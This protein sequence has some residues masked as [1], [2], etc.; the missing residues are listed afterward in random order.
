MNKILKNTAKIVFLTF[1]YAFNA[2]ASQP[3]VVGKLMGQ[4]GNQFF[5]IAATSC[6]AWDNGAEPYFPSLLTEQDFNIPL[7]HRMIFYNLNA[8]EPEQEIDYTYFESKFT[9]SPIPYQPNM[10]IFGWFQSDKYFR[11]RKQEIIE[12]FAPD[13]EIKCYLYEKYCSIIL[14]PKTVS[15]HYRSY[16]KE[17][18]QHIVYSKCDR[19][20]YQRAISQFSEDS[21]FVVFSNDIQWCKDNFSE[22]PR[23][24]IFIEGE[25][26]YH[27]IY[28][29]SMCRHNII[30][31]SSFSWWGSYL[32]TNP[33]KKVIAPKSWFS[34]SYINATDNTKDTSDLIPEE[35]ILL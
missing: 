29:M 6:L 14:N 11:H 23:K 21:I 19:D 22:I 20:Y 30:C 3:F 12:L 34:P 24:F 1:I 13:E 15:I 28:L 16:D 25:A 18:P 9:Y 26:H 27:D 31:N 5:I 2:M 10:S 32:N 8:A 4:L 7:N 17:D 35:W 33:E